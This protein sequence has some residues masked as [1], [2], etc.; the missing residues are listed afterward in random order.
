MEQKNLCPLLFIFEEFKKPILQYK[1]FET[2]LK[3]NDLHNNINTGHRKLIKY[4]V[5][6]IINLYLLQDSKDHLI[7][8]FLYIRQSALWLY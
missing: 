1:T 6:N 3:H 7:G 2:V 4:V 5:A 8:N